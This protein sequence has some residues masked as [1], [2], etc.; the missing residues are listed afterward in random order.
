[1]LRIKLEKN[2]DVKAEGWLENWSGYNWL[3]IV[4]N[5]DLCICDTFSWS[6]H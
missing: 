1:M 2:F 5:S 6:R 4:T 3:G